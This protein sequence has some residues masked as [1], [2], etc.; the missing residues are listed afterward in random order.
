M[1]NLSELKN[2]TACKE[3]LLQM[4]CE[5]DQVLAI[6]SAVFDGSDSNGCGFMMPINIS[7]LLPDDSSSDNNSSDIRRFSVQS[8]VNRRYVP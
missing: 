7:S 1:H 3:E 8:A 5:N 6:H 4:V 2:G